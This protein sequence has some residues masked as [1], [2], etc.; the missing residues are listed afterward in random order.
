M[1]PIAS[2][3]FFSYTCMGSLDKLKVIVE[4]PLKSTLPNSED[5]EFANRDGE[6]LHNIQGILTCNKP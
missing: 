3:E 5:V 1:P 6:S 4:S 2:F